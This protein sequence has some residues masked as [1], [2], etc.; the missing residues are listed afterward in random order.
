MLFEDICILDDN[1]V[2]REHQYV[3]VEGDR[4]ASIGSKRPPAFEGE[5]ISGKGRLLMPAF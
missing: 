2:V 1:F 4:I 3:V 5:V